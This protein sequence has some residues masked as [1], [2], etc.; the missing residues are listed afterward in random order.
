VIFQ[1]PSSLSKLPKTIMRS[2][3]IKALIVML[4]SCSVSAVFG[5]KQRVQ[6]R[7]SESRGL[8]LPSGYIKRIKMTNLL[9]HYTN[10][11]W[12]ECWSIDSHG[13]W[14]TGKTH[15]SLSWIFSCMRLNKY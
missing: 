5:G 2:S 15:H 11:I 9:T 6:H 8:C 10:D 1:S 12:W 13:N 7:L 4:K 14:G 3:E